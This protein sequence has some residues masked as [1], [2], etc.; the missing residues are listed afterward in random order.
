MK[1]LRKREKENIVES[2][3]EQRA[4]LRSS[5]EQNRCSSL[6]LHL[7]IFEKEAMQNYEGLGEVLKEIHFRLIKDGYI[8]K[9]GAFIK[10]DDGT[11]IIK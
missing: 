8:L 5:R 6:G 2:N 7:S 10:E 4:L 11:G 1:K 3:E 9:D